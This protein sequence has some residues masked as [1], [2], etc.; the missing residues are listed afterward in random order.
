VYRGSQGTSICKIFD[1][2]AGSTGLNERALKRLKR[3]YAKIYLH[4]ANHAAYYPRAQSL[5]L[6]L[7]F[8]PQDGQILGTQIV[9]SEGVDKRLDVLA[10]AQRARLTVFDLEHLELSYAPPYGSAKDPVNYAGMVAANA[11]RHDVTFCHPEDLAGV[12]AG[13]LILDVR[14]LPEFAAGAVPGALHIPIDDLR[15]RLQEI[16]REKELLIYCAV[17]LRSY[18]AARILAHHGWKTR[19]LSGGYTTYLAVMEAKSQLKPN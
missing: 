4:P 14:S 10:V 12:T 13:Q 15:D 5:S 18:L 8:D 1:L 17:G 19:V 16:P 7:I 11:L 9:G 6:K 3:P 2:A